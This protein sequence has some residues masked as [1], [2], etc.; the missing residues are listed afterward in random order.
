VDAKNPTDPEG[1]IVV[2]INGLAAQ[3]RRAGVETLVASLWRVDD[4]GTLALMTG[5]YDEL[6]SGGNIAV[7]LQRAQLRLLA[8]DATAHPWYWAAFVVVGDWR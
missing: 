3:F 4:A 5:L 6:A 1:G 2:S 7:S 8:D